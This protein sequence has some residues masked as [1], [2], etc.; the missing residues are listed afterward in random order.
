MENHVV[1]MY[2]GMWYSTIRYSLYTIINSSIIPACSFVITN[3][4]CIQSQIVT[5]C[6]WRKTTSYMCDIIVCLSAAAEQT[7]IYYTDRYICI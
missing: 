1:H 2:H 5:E 4:K 3:N 6:F 7:Y